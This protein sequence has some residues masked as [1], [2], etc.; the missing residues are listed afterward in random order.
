MVSSLMMGWMVLHSFTPWVA[1]DEHGPYGDVNVKRCRYVAMN[2]GVPSPVLQRRER[3]SVCIARVQCDERVLT[4]ECPAASANSC[5]AKAETCVAAF[6]QASV[7]HQKMG[8]SRRESEKIPGST[9]SPTGV[10]GSPSDDS[11]ISADSAR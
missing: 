4:I 8:S 11:G 7:S 10:P 5:P 6:L 1:A 2:A 9:D 3:R